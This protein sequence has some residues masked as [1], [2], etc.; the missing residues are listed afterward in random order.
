[1]ERVGA[2]LGLSA[3]TVCTS[4]LAKGIA[5]RN[6]HGQERYCG[7]GSKRYH[8]EISSASIRSKSTSDS[9]APTSFSIK[10]KGGLLGSRV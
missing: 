4:L 8:K 3:G 7:D 10:P 5:I 9:C 1:M 6:T 2:P